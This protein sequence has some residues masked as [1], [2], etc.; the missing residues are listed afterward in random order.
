MKAPLVNAERREARLLA[1]R[2]V[3]TAFDEHLGR[4]PQRSQPLY[5][6]DP[7]ARLALVSAIEQ[8]LGITFT[9]DDIEFVETESDLVHRGTL[10]LMRSD[11]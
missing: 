10:A 1:R 8:Q 3:A 7:M 11:S 9:D 6:L 2:A 4:G 5:S